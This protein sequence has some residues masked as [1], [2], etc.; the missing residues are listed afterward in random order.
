MTGASLPRLIRLTEV[1]HLTGLSKT[2]V[3]ALAAS[4]RFPPPVKL[5]ERS[6]A[7]VEAEVLQWIAARI[8]ERG[9]CVAA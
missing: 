4:D 3:Y 2:T 7:W 6:A 5:A 1:R 8:A 9:G